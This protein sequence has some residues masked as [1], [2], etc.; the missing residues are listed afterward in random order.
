MDR[1]GGKKVVGVTAFLSFIWE[2]VWLLVV[3][4]GKCAADVLFSDGVGD[5]FE[6]SASDDLEGFLGVNRAPDGL[7][8]AKV[9]F[10]GGE[11]FL[12]TLASCFTAGFREGCKKDCCGDLFDC[13][14]EVLDEGEVGVKGAS[15]VSFVFFKLTDVEDEFIDE[16]DDRSVF[17]EE[18]DELVFGW[19]G[20]F[21]VV[22]TDEI[23]G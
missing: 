11:G 1:I 9:V 14:G 21:K 3:K 16:D 8:P 2:V 23:V 15:G 19:C 18:R 5:G 20:S 17:G 10:K 6:E 22:G 4:F 7:Y 12:C 13:F